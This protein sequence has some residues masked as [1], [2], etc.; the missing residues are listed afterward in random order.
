MST[1]RDVFEPR[2]EHVVTFRAVARML[3]SRPSQ[4]TGKARRARK[5]R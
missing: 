1:L 4:G 5:E 2:L 3:L